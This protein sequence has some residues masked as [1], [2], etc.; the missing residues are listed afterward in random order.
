MTD[1]YESHAAQRL[2]EETGEPR[3]RFTADDKPLPE[4][5][6]LES[7]TDGGVDQ[8]ESEGDQDEW[9]STEI[10][11]GESSGPAAAALLS[12]VAETLV[13]APKGKRFD[14]E[15]VIEERDAS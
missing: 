9:L 11:A 7:V 1:Q 5:D 8:G 2:A 10:D 13:D 3:E 6:E 4:L 15:L 12:S 14:V